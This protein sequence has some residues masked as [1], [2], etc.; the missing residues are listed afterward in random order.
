[1]TATESATALAR[2]LF[3]V[4]ENSASFFIQSQNVSVLIPAMFAAALKLKPSLMLERR[5]STISGVFFVGLPP[6]CFVAT[7]AV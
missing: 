2:A 4:S 5:F 7:F 6:A 1:M 3:M